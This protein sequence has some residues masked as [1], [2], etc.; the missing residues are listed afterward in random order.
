MKKNP[1]IIHLGVFLAVLGMLSAGLLAY[2]YKKTELPIKEALLKK[3]SQTLKDVLPEFNNQPADETV[4][5]NADNGTKVTYF[6]AK[7]DNKIVGIAGQGYTLK[8]FNGKITVM[9]GLTPE[10]KIRT[11]IVTNQNETPGLGTVV[12]NRVRQKKI[13]DLFEKKKEETGLPPNKILDGFAGHIAKSNTPW[14]VK[15]DGGE[16]DFITGATISSR[17]VTDAVYTI[18]H[19]FIKHINEIVPNSK[20]KSDA[21]EVKTETKSK[22]N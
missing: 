14:S 2:V 11:V 9:V 16:F 4:T 21:K 10:G 19:T 8:G 5:I 17:A 20:I 1:G 7:K 15:K 3:T 13:T 6:I 18:A 22:K 12:T